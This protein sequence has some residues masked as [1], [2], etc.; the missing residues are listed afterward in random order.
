MSPADTALELAR[1]I[2]E[3]ERAAKQTQQ[4]IQDAQQRLALI[5][6]ELLRLRGKFSR[7]FNGAVR[8]SRPRSGAVPGT[9][10]SRIIDLLEE[11]LAEH[12]SATWNGAKIRSRIGGDADMATLR[13]TLVRLA[14]RGQIVKVSHGLYRGAAAPGGA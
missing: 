8:T 1:Q 4:T 3:H 14:K 12:P 6:S 5:G 7:L 11:L 10:T 13:S 9:I 2:G